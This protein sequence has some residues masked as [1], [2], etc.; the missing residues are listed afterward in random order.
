MK[1]CN[2]D[3][4]SFPSVFRRI[5]LRISIRKCCRIEKDLMKGF[6]LID[7]II[8]LVICNQFLGINRALPREELLRQRQSGLLSTL[9][10]GCHL[11]IF[12]PA[13]AHLV[14]IDSHLIVHKQIEIG[15]VKFGHL[16]LCEEVIAHSFSYLAKASLPDPALEFFCLCIY[17]RFIIKKVIYSLE[18]W[19]LLESVGAV[20]DLSIGIGYVLDFSGLVAGETKCCNHRHKLEALI[21]G[22]NHVRS[23]FNLFFIWL[24]P[25]NRLGQFRNISAAASKA[26]RPPG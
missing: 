1:C 20:D 11:A 8:T 18:G 21:T 10:I 7:F 25:L 5:N 14:E 4:D 15:L 24:Y 9:L 6:F 23:L 13:V 17:G 12:Q 26:A 2:T 19:V 22:N 16:P 3:S